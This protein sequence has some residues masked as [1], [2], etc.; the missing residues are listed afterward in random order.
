MQPKLWLIGILFLGILN[1]L[2]GQISQDCSTAIPICSN[3]PVNGGTDGFGTDDFSGADRSGCLLETTTGFIESNSAWYRFR[4]N[5]SGQLGFNI[6]FDSSEDWDF[7]LY[8][9]SDCNNLGDPVRCNFFDNSESRTYM[10]VGEDPGGATDTF[11]YEP[12]LDVV[13]GE[14]Y[15][16]LINNFSNTNSGFS[17]QFSG[18]IF[19]TNPNDALDCSIIDNLL[20]PPLAV[21]EG[22]LVQLDATTANAVSYQWFSDTGSGFTPIA[23]ATA[24]TYQPLTSALYRVQ[25]NTSDPSQIISDV[26]VAFSPSPTTYSLTDEVVCADMGSFDLSLKNTEALGSQ[27]PDAFR[28]SY[29]LSQAAADSGT[30]ALPV[31]WPLN[32]GLYTIYV[33][34]SSQTNPN[35]FDTSQQFN[36]EVLAMPQLLFAEEVFICENGGVAQIG[37]LNPEIGVSYSWDTGETTSSLNVSSPGSYTLTASR[38]QSGTNCVVQR[39]VAVVASTPPSIDEVL[40]EDL[41]VA[42]RVTIT[43]YAIGDFEYALDDGPFQSSPVFSEVFAGSHQ[44]YMRDSLGCGTVSE[45]ITVVG[46]NAFFTPNADGSNDFW[47]IEGL[48]ELSNPVVYIFDRYGKLLKQLSPDDPGW[49]GTFR[50][51]PLPASDY[52]FRLN[53]TNQ[54][55][56]RVEAKFLNAHFSLKR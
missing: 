18:N 11:L 35:C 13:P 7:A 46:Y 8:R 22:E 44:L 19:E 47:R 23:G 52:W 39:T 26:Q 21:C 25:V 2:N 41:Q 31:S 15:Y 51:N 50:G 32:P 20:G 4:T 1:I 24:A 53:Y 36:L 9:A 48:E 10:G 29:H 16:L 5:A 33:R 12:W 55:G 38:T 56:E 40:I 34:T 28:L 6:G 17:I 3:T 37:E 27:D 42:N 54:L 14:D 30:G 45:T 43:T 49:D